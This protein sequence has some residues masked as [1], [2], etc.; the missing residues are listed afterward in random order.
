LTGAILDTV[1]KPTKSTEPAQT[2]RLNEVAPGKYE[3]SVSFSKGFYQLSIIDRTFPQEALRYD[4]TGDLPRPPDLDVA[5]WVWPATRGNASKTNAWW[6]VILGVPLAAI[7]MFVVIF[8]AKMSSKSKIVP[9]TSG[10]E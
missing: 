8:L 6:V 4:M 7:L 9:N 1:L 5:S 2:I 3:A 10:S